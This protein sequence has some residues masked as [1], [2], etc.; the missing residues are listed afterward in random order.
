MIA[1]RA[2]VLG[3]HHGQIA[4]DPRRPG[5]DRARLVDSGV[6]VWAIVAHWQGLDGDAERTAADYQVPVAAVRAALD[7]YERHRAVIDNLIDANA[8]AAMPGG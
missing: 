6:P 4:P 1:R 5:A 7:Y 8:A 3:Q 2:P